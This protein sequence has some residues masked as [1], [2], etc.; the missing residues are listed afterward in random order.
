MII[1]E[2]VN[3]SSNAWKNEFLIDGTSVNPKHL[4]FSKT[5]SLYLQHMHYIPG[6]LIVGRD[7]LI[8]PYLVKHSSIK[9]AEQ[10]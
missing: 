10:T 1:P 9:C 2:F 3:S 6:T 8:N 7:F 4:I 5:L